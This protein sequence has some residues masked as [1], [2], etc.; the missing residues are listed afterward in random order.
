[1]GYQNTVKHKSFNIILFT[2]RYVR[3]LI[4]NMNVDVFGLFGGTQAHKH[5]HT[6]A[7]THTHTHERTHTHIWEFKLPV[8]ITSYERMAMLSVYLD[9]KNNDQSWST[10]FH[11]TSIVSSNF[12]INIITFIT[13]RN[14]IIY[15]KLSCFNLK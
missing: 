13:C 1:M 15:I 14:K 2:G 12:T 3:V 6:H 9:H 4:W 8:I 5:K 10:E 11:N 7:H